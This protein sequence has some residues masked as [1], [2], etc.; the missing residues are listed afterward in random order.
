ML[1]RFWIEDPT[2]GVTNIKGEVLLGLWDA[3]NAVAESRHMTDRPRRGEHAVGSCRNLDGKSAHRVQ[4]TAMGHA[5]RR[6]EPDQGA[7][8]GPVDHLVGD[9]VFVRDQVFLA[10][11]TAYRG[12]A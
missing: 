10:V 11:S 3:F 7:G 5:E 8:V 2:D 9:Q 12:I 4:I 6:I 1:L